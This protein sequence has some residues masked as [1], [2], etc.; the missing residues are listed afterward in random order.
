MQRSSSHLELASFLS[1]TQAGRTDGDQWDSLLPQPVVQLDMYRAW[2]E[3]GGH[4]A[5]AH[6]AYPTGASGSDFMSHAPVPQHDLAAANP[7]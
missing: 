4:K 7:T 3:G 6:A 2:P 1:Q 5:D